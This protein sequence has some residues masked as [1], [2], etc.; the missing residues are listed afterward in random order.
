[1]FAAV[2]Y[3][4]IAGAPIPV[5]LLARGDDVEKQVDHIQGIDNQF[6]RLLG[7]LRKAGGHSRSI[8][9]SRVRSDLQALLVGGLVG[10]LKLALSAPH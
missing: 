10:G 3:N 5:D 7:A 2:S 8:L 9:V 4:L 6:Q 1:M